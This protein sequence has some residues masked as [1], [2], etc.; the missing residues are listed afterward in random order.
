MLFVSKIGVAESRIEGPQVVLSHSSVKLKIT[1]EDA[2]IKSYSVANAQSAELKPVSA[3]EGLVVYETQEI[4]ADLISQ[5][6]L[7]VSLSNGETLQKTIQ[8]LPG[9]IAL[10]PPLLAV[11]IALTTKQVLLALFI[12]VASGVF[13]IKD[14]HFLDTFLSVVDEYL[15]GALANRDHASIIIFC[16][17]LGGVSG[18]VTQSGGELVFLVYSPTEFEVAKAVF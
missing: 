1:S 4:L 9:W 17:G 12:G 6:K 16:F 14:M 13:F 5:G 10:L 15:V 2:N 7:N 11:L 18:I 8:V 3:S